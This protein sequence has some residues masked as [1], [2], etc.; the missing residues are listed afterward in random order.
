MTPGQQALGKLEA[1]A[2]ELLRKSYQVHPQA[3]LSVHGFGEAREALD[4][5]LLE[6][7]RT[8]VDS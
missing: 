2:R 3:A 5:A 6:F 4:Q 8:R 1:T 7:E